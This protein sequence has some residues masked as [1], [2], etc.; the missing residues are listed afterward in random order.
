M[1]GKKIS[2]KASSRVGITET[3]RREALNYSS[4]GAQYEILAKLAERSP[5]SLGDLADET[6]MDIGELKHWLSKMFPDMVR[7]ME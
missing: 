5:M 3:G 1:F 7:V 2:L 4:R 6:D